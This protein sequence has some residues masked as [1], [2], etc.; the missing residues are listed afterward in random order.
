MPDEKNLLG[1]NILDPELE[2]QLVVDGYVYVVRSPYGA[3]HCHREHPAETFNR[4]RRMAAEAYNLHLHSP[5]STAP[6]PAG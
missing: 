1:A 5:T 6:D 3:L 4:W 2:A